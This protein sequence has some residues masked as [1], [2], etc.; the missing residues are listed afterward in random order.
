MERPRII[1]TLGMALMGIPEPATL[2]RGF[3]MRTL[4]GKFIKRQ[5]EAAEETQIKHW[6]NRA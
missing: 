5:S 3:P 4:I 2:V 1:H 6:H